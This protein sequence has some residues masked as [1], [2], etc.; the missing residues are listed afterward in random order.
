[1]WAGMFASRP[2]GSSCQKLRIGGNR[3]DFRVGDDQ[4]IVKLGIGL[5]VREDFGGLIQGVPRLCECVRIAKHYSDI[6]PLEPPVP[7]Q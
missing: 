7:L 4:E 2:I 5:P 3:V 1:M 6:L